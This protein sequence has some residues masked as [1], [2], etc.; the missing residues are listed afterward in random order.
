MG[1]LGAVSSCEMLILPAR[2]KDTARMPEGCYNPVN[3][4]MDSHCNFI[5]TAEG[6]WKDTGRI[7]KGYQT[8]RANERPVVGIKFRQSYVVFIYIWGWAFKS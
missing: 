5:C 4:V 2:Q 1:Q 7:P 8:G 6:Y 3:E